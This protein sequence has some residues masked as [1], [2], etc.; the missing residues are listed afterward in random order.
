[1]IGAFFS[2]GDSHQKDQTMIRSLEVSAICPRKR[3][4]AKGELIIN[5]AYMIRS[6]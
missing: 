4:R 6:T 5:H 3:R 2:M 1:V